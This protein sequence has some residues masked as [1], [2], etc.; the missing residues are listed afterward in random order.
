MHLSELF[1]TISLVSFIF[2][3]GN[4]KDGDGSDSLNGEIDIAN[5]KNTKDELGLYDNGLLADKIYQNAKNNFFSVN[6]SSLM[7]VN[8][9]GISEENFDRLL[10]IGSRTDVKSQPTD[11][12]TITTYSCTVPDDNDSDVICDLKISVSDESSSAEVDCADGSIFVLSSIAKLLDGIEADQQV[13][14]ETDFGEQRGGVDPTVFSYFDSVFS[15]CD[16]VLKG[17]IKLYA[18]SQ[19]EL[20]A[21]IAMLKDPSQFAK[22]AVTATKGDASANEKA[23]LVYAFK[24]L[25]GVD[26]ATASGSVAA[27]AS[28][29][30]LL[31]DIE[32]DS[33]LDLTKLDATQA[34]IY[35]AKFIRLG[36]FLERNIV[37]IQ[38][39]TQSSNVLSLKNKQRF[40][41]DLAEIAIEFTASGNMSYH[42]VKSSWNSII[43]IRG[44]DDSEL[45]YKAD[46]TLNDSLSKLDLKV[47]KVDKSVKI[48]G[49][50]EVQGNSK[51]YSIILTNDN[52]TCKVEKS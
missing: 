37:N 18:N 49:S 15:S 2:S 36:H 42:E 10:C 23:S 34:L 7:V 1:F 4:P 38:D 19:T 29:T 5:F 13:E 8:Q 43:F 50:G 46:Y 40:A 31:L 45:R 22:L 6:I 20:K 44:G 26:S 21:L 12:A 48:E 33:A 25:E 16:D 47:T 14:V 17:F 24:A 41:A 35:D 30:Q 39:E 51:N 28:E 3:C 52:S 27:G 11:V 9:G 32:V